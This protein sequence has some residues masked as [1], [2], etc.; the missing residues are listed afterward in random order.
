MSAEH[1]AVQTNDHCVKMKNCETTT[2]EKYNCQISSWWPLISSNGMGQ[3]KEL[4]ARM[5]PL[6]L[7]PWSILPMSSVFQ[8]RNTV[9]CIQKHC[10]EPRVLQASDI[11]LQFVPLFWN[12]LSLICSHLRPVFFYLK[13]Y[14]PVI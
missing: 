11:D 14:L 2:A 10:R 12:L 7:L 3:Q 9:L 8:D 4:I 1:S 6:L 13:C 5:H